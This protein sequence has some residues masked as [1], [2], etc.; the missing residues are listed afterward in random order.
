MSSTLRVIATRFLPREDS[1]GIVVNSPVPQS[2]VVFATTDDG[3]RL[4]IID[5][6]LPAFA[7][8]DDPQSVA[9]LDA[10]VRESEWRNA[11]V[12]GF[13]MRFMLRS[14]A[15]RLQLLADIINPDTSFLAGLTTY[16]MK[17]GAENL[18]PPF[19]SDVDRR[20]AGS[21]QA[22][23]V[24]LR[25]QQTAKLLAAALAPLLLA[26]PAAPLVLINIG[27]G[28]A[29]DSINALILLN[30]SGSGLLHRPIAIQVLDI[31]PAC[32]HF[33]AAAL[34]AL[35]ADGQPLAGIGISFAHEH[36]DWN[37]PAL[38]EDLVRRAA[39]QD[40]II[41]VSSEGALFEYG[42]DDAIT[43]NLRALHDNGAKAVVGSVTSADPLRRQSIAG[44]RFKLMPR[45]LDG[46]RPLAERGGFRI[47][48]SEAT[49]L[50]DQ[51]LRC[52]NAADICVD[53]G[54]QCA[55]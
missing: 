12:P 13:I 54:L 6:T 9:A 55:G 15:R 8:P 35:S 28:P 47:V 51:V 49:P 7:L 14:A 48:R 52:P 37:A 32:P 2:A 50:G 45:G 24:R 33:G 41:A 11:L 40:A 3:L 39:A 27:G 21:P 34:A 42:S 22:T 43:A 16:I 25:L 46:F 31:D 53:G 1:K 5:I 4:P 29:P 20:L 18:P 19:D 36:Y 26:A 17:L 44:G 38:L 10:A 30:R 23:A